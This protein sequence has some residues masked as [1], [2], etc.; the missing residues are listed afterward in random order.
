MNSQNISIDLV[1][2]DEMDALIQLYVDL[3]HNREPLTKYLGFSKE[4][5]ISFARSMYGAEQ[6][7]PLTRGF[8]WAARDRNATAKDVGFILCDDAVTDGNQQVP[9]DITETEMGMFSAVMALMGEVRKPVQKQIGTEAGKCLHVAA[10]G[11]AP[12]YEGAG[13]A[14][15]LLQTALQEATARE[16][17]YMFAECTSMASRRCHEKLGF[18]CLHSVVV[19]TFAMDGVRPFT[20]SN[21]DIYLLW[22]D[23][24]KGPC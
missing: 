14:T 4:R 21:T 23:L 12:G 2:P 24:Q 5:I 9:A 19:G 20:H 16:F 17:L 10:V 7:D 15:R 3:F 22:K 8:C 6:N 1:R 13:I 18:E 11:V